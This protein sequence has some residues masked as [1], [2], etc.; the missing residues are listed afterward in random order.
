MKKLGKAIACVLLTASLAPLSGCAVV[1]ELKGVNSSF[2]ES[3]TGITSV[4]IDYDHAHFSVRFDDNAEQLTISYP[5]LYNHRDEAVSVISLE[6][7]ET[8]I[9]I[10]EDDGGIAD[11]AF[12]IGEYELPKLTLV[13][14]ADRAYDLSLSTAY[15][16]IELQGKAT[17]QSLSVSV[18]TGE[19]RAER[20]TLTSERIAFTTDT[21]GIRMG[22][23]TADAV[24]LTTKNGSIVMEK[25]VKATTLTATTN[26]GEIKTNRGVTADTVA[27][28][29]NIGA[30]NALLIGV[31]EDYSVDIFS[32]TLTGHTSS[33]NEGGAK[34]TLK[35]MVGAIRV[36]YKN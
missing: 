23:T 32:G 36:N 34:V 4:Q 14:P 1:W 9:T 2:T 19:I 28:T 24:S 6:E 11:T 22:E 35:A 3:A 17:L 12:K 8:S 29:T 7:T 26:R 5:T 13:L 21:G 30:I 18:K 15:G 16:D 25:T 10:A 33:E 20:A 31:P 27:F